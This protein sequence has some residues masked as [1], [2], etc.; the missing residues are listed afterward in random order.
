MKNFILKHLFDDKFRTD[1]K[2]YILQSLVVFICI[3]FMLLLGSLFD[4]VIVA[5]L[6]ASSFILFVTPHANASRPRYV[7]GGYFCGVISGLCFNHLH[8]FI[9]NMDFNGAEYILIF[10]S[11]AAVAAAMF[12]MVITNTE[13]PPA[14]ALALG[15]S[16]DPKCWQTAAAAILSIILLSTIKQTFKKH[17]KNL[18]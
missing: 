14:A 6:G 2:H 17:L 7:I 9:L 12:M 3:S 4:H 10:I 8:Y 18:I 5:S 11:A 15:L 13:H 16:V 1:Y